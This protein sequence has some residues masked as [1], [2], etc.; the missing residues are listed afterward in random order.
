M[1]KIWILIAF[2][3]YMLVML[4][5]G[6]KSMKKTNNS[7]DFFL[8]GRGLGGWVAALS[9][10]ASD[11][12]GWL[13]MGLPGA[14]Y[15]LG[16][17][18]VWIAI[19]LLAGTILNW[20][21][22]STRLRRYTIKAGNSL[23][24]PQYFENRYRDKSRVL[25]VASSLFITIFFLVYTASAFSAG[26]KLFA[27]IFGI[28]YKI[29]LIIGAGII[30]TYTFMGGFWAVCVTDFIQGLLML[31]G[32]LFVPIAAY[33][34]IG[35]SEVTNAVTATGVNGDLYFN[36]MYSG[37]EK[38]GVIDIISQLGW[39][40]GYFGMPHILVRFMAVKSEKELNKSKLIA[41][42]WVTLS[43][44][45]ACFIGLIG[46]AYLTEVLSEAES[47]N[48]FIEMIL[49]MFKTDVPIMFIGGIFLCGIL[50]AIMSTA[51]SQLLV[52]ASSISEDLY[53]G[54]VNKDASDKKVLKIS[55]ITVL[56]VA[57]V[58]FIMALNPSNSVMGLVSNAWA[59][60]GAAFGPL[61]LC[62]IFWKRGNGVGAIIS[63]ISGGLTV[64]LWDYI[65][66][67]NG[68]TL[69]A[70]T[71]LYSLVVGFAVGLVG[72][73]I[74]S[75]VTKAPSEEIM[76]EFDEVKNNIGFENQA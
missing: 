16:T 20:L 73:I 65:P 37:S 5:I 60:F 1:D 53:K 11:M 6:A 67:Y 30:L 3:A 13:L 47:E 43:L 54:V 68:Q 26:G 28:E 56:L 44:A 57:I 22:V 50:A 38:M 8:G 49:Q 41:I 62:S 74:G 27:S 42:V 12:S 21:L 23:T 52:T 29:A 55:R 9:A 24:L 64:I 34:I 58:A 32:L 10:Q 36:I 7:E 15:M 4:A 66:L 31:I 25:R 2:A 18:Q 72:M 71:G 75:L 48:V 51:D 39:A 76:K 59:G 61:V 33:I 14:V 63:M 45:F 35:G 19:G 17:G 40:L 70:A 46:R 69:G